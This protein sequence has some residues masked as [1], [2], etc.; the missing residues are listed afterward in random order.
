[1]PQK[2]LRLAALLL[3]PVFLGITVYAGFHDY[4]HKPPVHLPNRT[5][6]DQGTPGPRLL[7][8]TDRCG[9][10]KLVVVA[11]EPPLESAAPIISLTPIPHP[12]PD[13]RPILAPDPPPLSL[14][15]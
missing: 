9:Q 7:H 15:I 13:R 6:H 8:R 12:A 11:P 14:R 1:L 3:I 5:S 4:G 10:L 2:L